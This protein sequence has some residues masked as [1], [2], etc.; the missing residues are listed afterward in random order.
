M[1][2]SF[3]DGMREVVKGGFRNILFHTFH[4]RTLVFL[5]VIHEIHF[6]L[7][8][9][10]IITVQIV[11]TGEGGKRRE[12][13]RRKKE[14]KKKKKRKKEGRKREERERE[15]KRGRETRKLLTC[16]NGCSSV[17]HCRSHN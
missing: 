4:E 9:I 7:A 13:K 3:G 5:V 2:A 8:C 16:L 17:R 10:A 14:K 15:R 11:R 12:R 1:T 6:F